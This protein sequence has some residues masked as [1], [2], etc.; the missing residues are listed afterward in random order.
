MLFLKHANLLDLIWRAVVRQALELIYG[1]CL[2]GGD[3]Q[4]V[5]TFIIDFCCVEIHV[6]PFEIN[7]CKQTIYRHIFHIIDTQGPESNPIIS[8]SLSQNGALAPM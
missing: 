4:Y 7:M 1:A 8:T 6:C 2:A 3:V 5:C